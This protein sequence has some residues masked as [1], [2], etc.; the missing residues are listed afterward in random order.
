[1]NII[2]LFKMNND[3]LNTFLKV[4]GKIKT[5]PFLNYKKI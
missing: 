1:M 3:E 2:E 4:N 5:I